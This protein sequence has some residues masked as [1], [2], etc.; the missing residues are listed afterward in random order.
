MSENNDVNYF[1]PSLK[2]ELRILVLCNKMCNVYNAI[3]FICK[4]LAFLQYAARQDCSNAPHRTT[5]VRLFQKSFKSCAVC[6][7][8]SWKA[9]RLRQRRVYRTVSTSRRRLYL[10]SEYAK[11][12]VY[13]RTWVHAYHSFNQ[14]SR[15][16]LNKKITFQNR[17]EYH[18]CTVMLSAKFQSRVKSSGRTVLFLAS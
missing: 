11:M 13:G 17:R 2:K 1:V 3:C 14:S 6:N 7:F 9:R 16:L 8:I 18:F 5:L 10:I 4:N 15:P 12:L